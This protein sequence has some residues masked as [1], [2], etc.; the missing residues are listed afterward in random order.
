MG[1]RACY[2]G[3]NLPVAASAGASNIGRIFSPNAHVITPLGPVV[4]A[5]QPRVVQSH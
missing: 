3:P 2:A 5:R 4:L 1:R